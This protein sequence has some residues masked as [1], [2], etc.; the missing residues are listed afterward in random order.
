MTGRAITLGGRSFM[1]VAPSAQQVQELM[2]LLPRLQKAIEV[3][4]QVAAILEILKVMIARTAPDVSLEELRSLNATAPEL[5]EAMQVVTELTRAPGTA[6]TASAPQRDIG[7]EIL[8]ELTAIRIAALYANHA[9]LKALSERGAVDPARVAEIAETF[10]R[11]FDGVGD[12]SAAFSFPTTA[13][14]TRAAARILRE[15]AAEIEALPH[16]APGSGLS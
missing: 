6:P 7:N 5:I 10:A 12:R 2:P 8:V 16:M 15:Y 1:L 13:P 14:A 3:D 11:G 9:L 4:Q